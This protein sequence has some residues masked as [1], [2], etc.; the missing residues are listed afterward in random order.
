VK[1]VVWQIHASKGEII[2]LPMAYSI[3]VMLFVVSVVQ[4]Q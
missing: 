4:I 2:V 3:V 1:L